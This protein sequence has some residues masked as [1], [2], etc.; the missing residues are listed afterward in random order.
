MFIPFMN[1]S[2]T[3]WIRRTAES[4]N[5]S[6]CPTDSYTLRYLL[7]LLKTS[8]SKFVVRPR[9]DLVERRTS[10][11]GASSLLNRH[12]ERWHRHTVPRTQ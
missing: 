10:G 8:D 12:G 3:Q 9:P 4:S 7:E 6:F 2:V 1:G 5:R 11:F